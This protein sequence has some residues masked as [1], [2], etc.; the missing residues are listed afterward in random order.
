MKTTKLIAIALI[1]GVVSLGMA[2]STADLKPKP[3]PTSIVI[4]LKKAMQIPSLTKAMFAQL[5]PNFLNVEKP[6]YTVLVKYKKRIQ[7]VSGTRAEWKSFFHIDLNED[8]LGSFGR[9][10]P[11][12]QAIHNPALLRSMRAQLSPSMLQNDKQVYTASVRYK[13][14]VVYISGSYGEWKR[15]FSIKEK[16][17]PQR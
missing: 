9:V 14:S 13:H 6:V 10:I 5:N 16:I 12:K 2:Q 8:P 1:L 3:S 17:A 4:Q 11:L 15:F 7:Y